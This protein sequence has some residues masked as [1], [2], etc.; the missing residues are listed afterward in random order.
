MRTKA[1]ACD[2]IIALKS[3]A[4]RLLE[5]IANSHESPVSKRRAKR[6]AAQAFRTLR[7]AGLIE[8]RNDERARVAIGRLT[9]H[10]VVLRRLSRSVAGM[11]Q[12]GENP[13]LQAAIVKDLG[14]VWEKVKSS[15]EIGAMVIASAISFIAS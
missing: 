10:L 14:T 8:L 11:L 1:A 13:A 7:R 6:T 12:R 2:A 3:R 4:G 5:L 15:G 9:A